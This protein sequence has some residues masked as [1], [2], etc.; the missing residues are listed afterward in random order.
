MSAAAGPSTLDLTG[1]LRTG[2]LVIEAS[3][4]TGK[5]YS[6]SALVVRHIAE[7]D[8]QAS[9][10]LLVTFTRA[11]AAE[12]RD[13]TRRV[14]VAASTA[15]HEGAVVDEHRWMRVLLDG[16]DD[17][18]AE[19]RRRVDAAIRAFDEA[20]ITT[21]Q[22]FCQIALRQLGLR[23]GG[24]VDTELGANQT[25]YVEEV[26]RDLVVQALHRDI[27]ALSWS[28]GK[29]PVSPSTVLEQLKKSVRAVLGNRGVR[30]VPTLGESEAHPDDRPERLRAWVELVH[31]AVDLVGERQRAR[32]EMGYDELITGLYDA[33]HHPVTGSAAVATLRSRYKLVMVDEFQDTDAVQWGTFATIF[34]G[35]LITVGDPKKAIYRFRGADVYAYLEAVREAPTVRLDTNYRS[36]AALVDAT[37]RL[38]DG[39]HLGDHRIVA[40]PVGS[41]TGKAASSLDAGP[42]LAIRRVDRKCVV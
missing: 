14:L 18:V 21:I 25:Q 9:E 38:I 42:P 7:R 4:G 10:L 33:V 40:T 6:L 20:T 31:R 27:E 23:A 24:A 22:G 12:L 37:N 41:P 29:G 5:T 13:R 8:R 28:D 32:Q 11:A 34:D 35:D 3:A 1:E 15:L 17:E 36:D 39:V 19:R 2:R 16:S 30:L 26:C